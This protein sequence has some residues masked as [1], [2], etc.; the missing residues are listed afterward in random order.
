MDNRI[1][2]PSSRP[3][4]STDCLLGYK[5]VTLGYNYSFLFRLFLVSQLGQ[6]YS[7]GENCVP[8]IPCMLLLIIHSWESD[9]YLSVEKGGNL[10]Y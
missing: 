2:L 6:I 8:S 5:Y 3:S 10:I 1:Y 7:A 9:H 4:I